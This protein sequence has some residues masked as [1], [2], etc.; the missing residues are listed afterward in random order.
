M[1]TAPPARLPMILVLT[2]VPSAC[3]YTYGRITSAPIS[4][5][6][7][8][9]GLVCSSSRIDASETVQDVRSVQVRG[10]RHCAVLGI[11]WPAAALTDRQTT[12]QAVSSTYQ[13]VDTWGCQ[14]QSL[15]HGR[16]EGQCPEASGKGTATAADHMSMGMQGQCMP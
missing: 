13:M 6:Q 5:V 16:G 8:K 4:Q 2:H 12:A 15:C 1:C 11:L 7:L 9:G 10:H 3:A 14:Q